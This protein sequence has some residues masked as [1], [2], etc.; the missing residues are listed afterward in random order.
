MRFLLPSLFGAAFVT[1]VSAVGS[2]AE[3]AMPGIG[4][5][6]SQ[7]KTYTPIE[8]AGYRRLPF[9]S[10]PIVVASAPQRNGTAKHAQLLG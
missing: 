6:P 4:D 7:S 1:T 3:T 2:E 5:L 8:K 10:C 9:D